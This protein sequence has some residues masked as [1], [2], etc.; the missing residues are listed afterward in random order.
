LEAELFAVVILLPAHE[1]QFLVG[2]FSQSAVIIVS[3]AGIFVGIDLSRP[4]NLCHSH[5]GFA[6]VVVIGSL[7]SH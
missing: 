1:Y 4:K 3:S 5:E 2:I 6:T 7:Y